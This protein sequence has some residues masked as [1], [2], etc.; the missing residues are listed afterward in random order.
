MNTNSGLIN[1][2]ILDGNGG[3]KAVGWEEI[4]GWSEGDGIL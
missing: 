3:G 2:Y 1:A 4:N